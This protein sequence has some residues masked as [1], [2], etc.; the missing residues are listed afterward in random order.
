LTAGNAIKTLAICQQKNLKNLNLESQNMNLFTVDSA[1]FSS[2]AEAGYANVRA[3]MSPRQG[4]AD[5]CTPI[6]SSHSLHRKTPGNA[7]MEQTVLML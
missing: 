2:P 3:A 1:D 6:Q 7:E 5:N 4:G